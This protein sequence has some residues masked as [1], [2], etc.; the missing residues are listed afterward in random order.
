MWK[1]KQLK[2]CIQFESCPLGDVRTLNHPNSLQVKTMS[3]FDMV[4]KVQL[5]R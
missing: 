1:F 2:P 3:I 4:D 5:L